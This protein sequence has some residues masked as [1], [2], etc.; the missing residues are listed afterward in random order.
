MKRLLQALYCVDASDTVGNYEISDDVHADGED[1][2][3]GCYYLRSVLA[4]AAYDNSSWRLASEHMEVS[5]S[6][7]SSLQSAVAF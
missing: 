4:A 1:D 5:S 3:H 6:N 2:D 7:Q